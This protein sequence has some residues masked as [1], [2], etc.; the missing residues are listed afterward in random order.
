MTRNRPRQRWAFH[1]DSRSDPSS[2]VT[3]LL[4]EFSTLLPVQELEVPKL[5]RPHCNI[6]P[7]GMRWDEKQ[8]SQHLLGNAAEV[9]PRQVGEPAG[10]ERQ[11]SRGSQP[12]AAAP[13]SGP[14]PPALLG[15]ATLP[16]KEP[17]PCPLEVPATLH[18]R[19]TPHNP[20]VITDSN[21]PL[22]SCFHKTHPGIR[23]LRFL[24]PSHT[25]EIATVKRERREKYAEARKAHGAVTNPRRP[26]GLGTEDF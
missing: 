12:S 5:Q 14:R 15:V 25:L 2:R 4:P 10:G 22:C 1:Q 21:P 8:S 23:T 24:G 16:G 18:H 3:G 13:D 20:L 26:E 17:R 7:G 6:T 11:V 19:V 9:P